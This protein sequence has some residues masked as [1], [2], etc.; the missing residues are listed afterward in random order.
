MNINVRAQVF[1]LREEVRLMLRNEP[2]PSALEGEGRVNTLR[3]AI[4]T[5]TSYRGQHGF[6]LRLPYSTSKHAILGLSRSTA[7]AYA[8]HG[9]RVNQISPGFI[10]TPMANSTVTDDE[11]IQAWINSAVPLKRRGNPRELAD[12]CL[13]LCSERATYMVGETVNCD[14]GMN[15]L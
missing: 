11:Q 4:V 1:L 7:V 8:E 3:G 9:V 13:Y 10:D 6:P 14:G 2:L 5:F 12:L 15:V